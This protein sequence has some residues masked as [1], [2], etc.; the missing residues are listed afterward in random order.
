MMKNGTFTHIIHP[1]NES[2]FK[3]ASIDIIIFRY[4][5][6]NSL[7]KKTLLNN[8]E[9]FIIN[10]DGILTFS[11]KEN[12]HFKTFKDYFDIYVG[13]VTGKE[14]VYKNDEFGNITLLNGKNKIDKYILINSFQLIIKI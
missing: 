11:N 4:C 14:N 12:T 10:S 1:N 3:N 8:E 13:M 2:L 6:N 5:K 7:P 9:K